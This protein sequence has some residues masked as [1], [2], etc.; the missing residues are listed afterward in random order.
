MRKSVF[1][2]RI[3]CSSRPWVHW[4]QDLYSEP[5]ALR[6]ILQLVPVDS[7]TDWEVPPW[8]QCAFFQDPALLYVSIPP[9]FQTFSLTLSWVAIKYLASCSE[10]GKVC[11]LCFI[12][13]GC[14]RWGMLGMLKNSQC[15]ISR[16]Y[17]TKVFPTTPRMLCVCIHK[18]SRHGSCVS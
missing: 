18:I 7:S 11:P 10:K 14:T 17:F 2:Y 12:V 8:E 4:G 5:S 3:S 13:T 1:C 15:K 16:K 9:Y 6:Q